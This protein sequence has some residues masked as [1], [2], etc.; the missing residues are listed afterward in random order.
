MKKINSFVGRGRLGSMI[1][2][3]VPENS[4]TSLKRGLI[5]STSVV[6]QWTNKAI[7]SPNVNNLIGVPVF[8]LVL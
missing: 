2:A 8:N 4:N 5:C 6:W 7:F 1:T 3:R